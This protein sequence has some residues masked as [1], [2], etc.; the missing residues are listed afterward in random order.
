MV[1]DLDSSGGSSGFNGIGPEP[2][3]L[4]LAQSAISEVETESESGS[5]YMSDS[6]DG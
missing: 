4:L 3:D 5:E 6:S 2:L 1:V